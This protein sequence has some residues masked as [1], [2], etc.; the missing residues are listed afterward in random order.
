MLLNK[1]KETM[2]FSMKI[3]IVRSMVTQED[4]YL[5]NH[6]IFKRRI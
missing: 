3:T 6:V 1:Y 2:K 4:T 5:G